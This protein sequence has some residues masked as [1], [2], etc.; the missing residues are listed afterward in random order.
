MRFL[1]F[2]Q[3]IYRIILINQVFIYLHIKKG[4]FKQWEKKSVNTKS[5]N[6]ITGNFNISCETF[7]LFNKKTIQKKE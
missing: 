5:N 2:I 1:F 7:I 3:I 6:I 4:M